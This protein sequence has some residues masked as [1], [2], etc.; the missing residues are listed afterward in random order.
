MKFIP[1]SKTGKLVSAVIWLVLFFVIYFAMPR[2]GGHV[3]YGL[4]FSKDFATHL[5]LDW[6]ETYIALLDDV[7]VRQ[8]R[9]PTYWTEVEFTKDSYYFDNIDWQ[10]NE[11]KKRNAKL[12]LSLGQ[13]QPRWPEC[14]IPNWAKD[15]SVKEKQEQLLDVIKTIVERYK[16]DDAI[17]RWQ[18]ENEPYLPFGDCPKFDEDFLD[19]EISLVRL[20]DRSRPIIISDSGELG[21]WYG[22]GKRADILGTTLYRIVWDKYL[23]YVKYPISSLVYRV[24]AAIIMLTT[25]VEKIIIVE[26]QAEPWGPKM[27]IETPIDEQFRSMGIEQFRSNIAF[28]KK[29]EFSEAYLWGGEWWYWLKTKQNNSMIWDEAKIVFKN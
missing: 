29:V 1:R 27:I 26:L 25:N 4:T 19:S 13:K 12:I 28:V 11:A 21:T 22:A 17:L 20:L 10:I 5:G 7:G 8:L 24:K 14:H 6:K 9:I 16:N 18:V 15:I 23:G 3:I 2:N